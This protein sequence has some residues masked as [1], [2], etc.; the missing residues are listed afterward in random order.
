MGSNSAQPFTF[1]RDARRCSRGPSTAAVT[2]GKKS[3]SQLRRL[4]QRAEARGKGDDL[5][6]QGRPSRKKEP[7]S[8]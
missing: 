5:H 6:H 7:P 4:R 1:V 8:L 3:Q 2:M